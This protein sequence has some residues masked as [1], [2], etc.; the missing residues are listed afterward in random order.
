MYYTY[1]VTSSTRLLKSLICSRDVI[2]I[3]SKMYTTL[4]ECG[5]GVKNEP[6]KKYYQYRLEAKIQLLLLFFF[7]NL[8]VYFNAGMSFLLYFGSWYMYEFIYVC[9]IV[10]VKPKRSAHFLIIIFIRCAENSLI[11]GKL[12]TIIG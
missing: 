5:E 8:Y 4:L 9:V 1:G 7:Y 3:G 12:S 2:C 10:Y 6:L 11:P